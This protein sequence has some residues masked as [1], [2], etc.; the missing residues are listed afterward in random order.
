M[1]RRIGF[2]M[3]GLVF[4]S[5]VLFGQ[6]AQED[7][8]QK[9]LK[10]DVDYII[11]PAEK[12]MF[13]KLKTDA[14]REEFIKAFWLR[15]D[16][17]PDTEVN[18]YQDEYYERIAYANKNFAFGNAA[19]WRADRGRIYILFG[20]PDQKLKTPSGEIWKYR[21]ILALRAGSEFEFIH[22]PGTDDL[23]LRA[24]P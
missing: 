10:E 17:D 8:Y 11:E 6:S 22:I 1:T 24:Q 12:K 3:A 18:E 20:E 13:L 19:G 14:E 4:G 23:R 16:P 15:R 7:R 21:Y 2:L 9:W 5:I